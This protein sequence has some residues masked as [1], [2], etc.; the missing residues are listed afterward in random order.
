VGFRVRVDGWPCAYRERSLEENYIS[1][2]FN[3]KDTQTNTHQTLKI[4]LDRTEDRRDVT[5]LILRH[6][7]PYRED[8]SS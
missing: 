7:N 4:F 6:I 3:F 8:S 5:F 1:L 2:N